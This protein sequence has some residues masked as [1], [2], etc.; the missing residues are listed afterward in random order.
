MF[1][2]PLHVLILHLGFKYADPISLPNLEDSFYVPIS[3][4][5]KFGSFFVLTEIILHE[6]LA[7]T[8]R[9]LSFLFFFFIFF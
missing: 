1:L 6:T 4:G 9:Y 2:Y 5:T 8:S 7:E 3:Y